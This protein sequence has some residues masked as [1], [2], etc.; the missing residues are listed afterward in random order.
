MDFEIGDL[1]PNEIQ[2]LLQDT[3]MFEVR[4]NL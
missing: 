4:I 3:A 1:E 2:H